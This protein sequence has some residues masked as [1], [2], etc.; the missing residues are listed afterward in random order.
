MKAQAPAILRLRRECRIDLEVKE[1]AQAFGLSAA[2]GNFA[3]L[4]VVHA[5]LVGA[6]EPGYDF[7]DAIDVHQVG[8]V[9]APEEVLVKRFE[10]FFEEWMT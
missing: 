6:L 1:L 7:L 9:G 10:Q 3:L 5:E 8:A 4:L 2:D